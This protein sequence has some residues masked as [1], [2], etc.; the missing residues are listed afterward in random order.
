[1]K[2][3]EICHIYMISNGFVSS[4]LVF[5]PFIVKTNNNK[6]FATQD[7][8]LLKIFQLHNI[9]L[10]PCQYVQCVRACVRACVRC[11]VCVYVCVCVGGWWGCSFYIVMLEPLLMSILGVSFFVKLLITFDC[12]YIMLVGALQISIII[13]IKN[14]N[15]CWR[16]N[17]VDSV[18]E[19]VQ[20]V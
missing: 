7:I 2:Y 13:I 5:V 20:D 6:H 10:R 15:H 14:Q 18:H 9:V 4:S 8:S 17:F 12:W 1:M 16:I 3:G 19:C 11:V